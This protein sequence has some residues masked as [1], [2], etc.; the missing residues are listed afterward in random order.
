MK[1]RIPLIAASLFGLAAVS[2]AQD[3]PR[4][5]PQDA[6]ADALANWLCASNGV[7]LDAPTRQALKIEVGR[8]TRDDV[9]RLLGKP[10]RTSND[11]DCEATQ[12]GAIWEYL[13]RDANGTPFRVHVAFSTAG[14]VS[15]VARIPQRG[16]SVVLAYAA[17]QAHQHEM[18]RMQ[19]SQ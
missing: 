4:D 11:A 6:Q 10:W 15:L 12:Y 9:G 19:R 5:T 16:R 14:T 17:E 8:A 2:M 3:T 18:P 1:A 7:A 13:F